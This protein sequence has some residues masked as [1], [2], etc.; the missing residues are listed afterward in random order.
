MFKKL[1]ED[2]LP[3]FFLIQNGLDAHILQRLR[4]NGSVKSDT[5]D[6][7]CRILNCNVEDVIKYIP[8]HNTG[9]NGTELKNKYGLY[10]K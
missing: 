8:D 7:V 1:K 9:E 3:Q 10:S 5:L 2:G 4:H 6:K